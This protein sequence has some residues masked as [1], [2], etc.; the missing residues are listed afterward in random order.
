MAL[1]GH[2]RK[3]FA[4]RLVEIGAFIAQSLHLYTCYS[5]SL[6]V[7]MP[8][9]LVQLL[10]RFNCQFARISTVCADSV[11]NDLVQNGFASRLVEVGSFVAPTKSLHFI[12]LASC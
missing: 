6:A 12:P 5:L 4:T 9:A 7:D 3:G 10:L 1:I 8:L 11:L 2:L